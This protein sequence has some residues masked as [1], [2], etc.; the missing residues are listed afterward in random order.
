MVSSARMPSPL[1]LLP[2]SRPTSA[3][4]LQKASQITLTGMSLFYPFWIS[5]CQGQPVIRATVIRSV[6]RTRKLP[7]LVLDLAGLSGAPAWFWL[8]LLITVTPQSSQEL[9]PVGAASRPSSCVSSPRLCLH[10]TTIVTLQAP[11]D[12]R[13][14][15]AHLCNP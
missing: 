11:C 5:P 12:G 8:D 15:T 13:D 2:F 10:F 1:D 14:A 6:H 3:H 4:L 7:R 9:L